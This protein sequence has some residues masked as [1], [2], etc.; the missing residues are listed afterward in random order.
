[1]FYTIVI[2]CDDLLSF[3]SNLCVCYINA[4]IIYV[5]I[6]YNFVLTHMYP[7][8]IN[9]ICSNLYLICGSNSCII[10]VVFVATFVL[11]VWKNYFCSNLYINLCVR[12]LTPFLLLMCMTCYVCD[13]LCIWS[14]LFLWQLM[15]ITNYDFMPLCF[16][17]SYKYFL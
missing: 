16:L 4:V 10:D 14:I 12:H 13:N 7:C 8:M 2:L 5:Y 9:I 1:M 6:N 3:C 15:F 17:T 11:H